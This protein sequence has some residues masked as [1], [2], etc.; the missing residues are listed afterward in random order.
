MNRRKKWIAAAVEL[1]VVIM[2]TITAFAWGKR[3]AL[4]ERGYTAHG[5][6]YMLLL[7]P[8]IYCTGKRTLLDWIAELRAIWR[9][10]RS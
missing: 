6:E 9:N 5:G 4:I 1:A 2:V 7:I 3:D 10:G 8:T